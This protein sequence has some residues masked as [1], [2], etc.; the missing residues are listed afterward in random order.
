M[1]FVDGIWVDEPE[2]E[3]TDTPPESVPS[4]PLEPATPIEKPITQSILKTIKKMLGID[5]NHK[6]FDLD[7]IVDINAT[8]LTLNEL[9]IGPEY[10]YAI[11]G[12]SETWSD[13]LGDQEKYLAGVQTY[14][15]MRVR[16]MF[17]PPSN[18]FL[19]DSMQ[20]QIQEFEW[21]FTV[22]PKDDKSLKHM[23]SFKTKI[24]PYD[25]DESSN[26]SASSS[27]DSDS[28]GNNSLSSQNPDPNQNGSSEESIT[29]FSM[30]K[31]NKKSQSLYDI[32]G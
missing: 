28:S 12:E 8:F 23:N 30:K 25:E 24:P 5:E 26:N 15:Y 22:Q 6:A 2:E 14:V 17:D 9:G 13:F 20:K 32:F 7:V 11:T 21:R 1:P 27:E 16:L 3:S 18:S 4:T 19:V 10:P 31:S 29:T